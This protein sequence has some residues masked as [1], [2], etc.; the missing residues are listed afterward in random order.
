GRGPGG[1]LGGPA[2]PPGAG[3]PPP[4]GPGGGGGA[5]RQ[6]GEVLALALDDPGIVADIDTLEDLAR[7][8]SLLAARQS[9]QGAD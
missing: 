7:A 3:P 2:P 8:E 6:A 1:G 5:R 4:R 9:L